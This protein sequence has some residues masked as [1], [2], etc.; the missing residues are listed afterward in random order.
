MSRRKKTPEP[1]A[2]PDPDERDLLGDDP[3]GDDEE[4]GGDD[5]DD[6]DAEEDEDDAQGAK[7]SAP[8]RRGPKVGDKV[9]LEVLANGPTYRRVLARVVAVQQ[10]LR[11]T[12]AAKLSADHPE[13]TFE[14]VP[15]HDRAGGAR[16]C[17]R[18]PAGA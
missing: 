3:A 14:N 2:E 5:E 7:G 8:P 16:P 1:P 11:L 17:W 10:E 15:H 4:D 18:W 9:E 6:E 13:T 12:L